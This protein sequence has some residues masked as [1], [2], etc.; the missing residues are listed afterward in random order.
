MDELVDEKAEST[1]GMR[2]DYSMGSFFSFFLCACSVGRHRL[3]SPNNYFHQYHYN[4]NP[5]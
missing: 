5:Y 4:V 1:S 3:C 2:F